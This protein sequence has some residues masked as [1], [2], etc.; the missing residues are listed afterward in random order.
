MCMRRK[1]W[2]VYSP[3]RSVELL[4][5]LTSVKSQINPNTNLYSVVHK[6]SIGSIK[7]GSRLVTFTSI[8]MYIY[9]QKE[10]INYK[11]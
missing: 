8:Y 10:V 2:N 5:W 9:S 1:Y 6:S 3:S 11:L 4:F 7:I